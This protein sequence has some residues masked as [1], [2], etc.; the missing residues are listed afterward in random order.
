MTDIHEAF[1]REP[2]ANKAT[3]HPLLDRSR[4]GLFRDVDVEAYHLGTLGKLR[5]DEVSISQSQMRRILEETPLDFAF[6]HPQ[7][8]PD[9]ERLAASVAMHRGDL[10]HQ[11][12]LG[13]GRG[14]EVAPFD[15]YRT[16]AAK[17]WRDGVIAEGKVPVKAKDFE[18]AEIMAEVIRER[19]DETLD[20]APYETEVAFLYQEMTLDGPVWVRG[21]VDVWCEEKLTILDPKITPMIY[22]G[23]VE[24]QLVNMGWDRQAALYPHAFGAILGAEAAGR[25]RFRDLMIKPEEPFTSRVVA[26]E[27]GWYWSAL[28]QCQEA[29]ERFGRC[30]YAGKWPGFVNVHHAQLPAWEDKRREA[31]ETGGE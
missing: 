21:M 31:I 2:A 30:L 8:N 29:I 22:D 15:D 1:G 13:K 6:H 3:D 26:L 16:T 9:R 10:V 27:K 4:W 28:K 25:I 7:I 11:L 24:R 5:D 14:Y 20:G 23:K 12:A 19:I 17:N 18:E